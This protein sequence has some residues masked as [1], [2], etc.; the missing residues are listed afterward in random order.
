M[1][2]TADTRV[3]A[4]LGVL[5]WRLQLMRS[6]G[7]RFRTRRGIAVLL[8]AASCACCFAVDD[9]NVLAAGDWSKPVGDFVGYTLRGRLILC[10][11]PKNGDAAIYVE[12]QEC[13]RAAGVDMDVYCNMNPTVALGRSEEHTSE[14]QSL[15]HL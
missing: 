2:L 4:G 1:Q 8:L 6:V 9:T 13:S 11:S 3:S 15:R 12:L 14:L 10:D 5:E 7:R